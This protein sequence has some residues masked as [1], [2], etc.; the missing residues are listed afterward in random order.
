MDEQARALVG[1]ADAAS[2]TDNPTASVHMSPLAGAAIV[3]RAGI[4]PTIQLT[5]RDR[6]RLA[7]SADLLGAWVLG[8]RNLLC[9]TGDPLSAGDDPDAATVADLSV[10]DLIRLATRLRDEGTLLSGRAVEDPPAYFVGVADMPLV[11]GYDAGRLEAK[12]NAGAGFFITQITYDVE[13][14]AAWADV[15]RRRGLL[16]RAAAFIGVAPLRSARQA[17]FMNE[18]VPGVSVPDELIRA[19]EDAGPDAEAQGTRQA[20]DIVKRLREIPGLAGIHVMGMGHEEGVRGVIEG[21]G[22]LPR[23]T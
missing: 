15:V 12:L 9:L 23:P 7:L 22:L 20:I 5:V 8:A 10:Q 2:V 4:E 13:A 19:L 1:Y 21:A 14:L 11:P 6:N 17:R 3:A 16:E 18:R